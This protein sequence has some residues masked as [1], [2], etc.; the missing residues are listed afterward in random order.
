MFI[1]Q[2]NSTNDLL[3]SLITDYEQGKDVSEDVRACLQ[4]ALPV[5]Y[6]GF[7]TAGRGQAGN[8]WESEE[9]KNLLFSVLL[10]RPNVPIHEGFRIAMWAA[11]AIVKTLDYIPLTIKWPNDIYYKDKKLCGMLIENSITSAGWNYSII[12]VGLNV[13]QTE[14]LSAA[15]NPI[16]IATITNQMED[17]SQLLDRIIAQ[18]VEDLCLLEDYEELKR[19]YVAFLYRKDGYHYYVERE[20][21]LQPTDNQWDDMQGA[22]EAKIVDI[23]AQGELVLQLRDEQIRTYHFKQIRYV[24]NTKNEI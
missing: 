7:Q 17:L 4:Q 18:M 3:R 16:S 20:V 23:T 13:N 11:L 24:I 12:G 6:T 8:S 19:Q 1:K 22:F 5:V 14:W 9:G 15:P 10:K 2:T 21:S